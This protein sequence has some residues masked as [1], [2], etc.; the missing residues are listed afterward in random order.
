ML[1]ANSDKKK[2]LLLCRANWL[3]SSI[4]LKEAAENS[5]YQLEILDPNRFILCLRQTPTLLYQAPNEP[6]AKPFPLDFAGVIPRFGTSST[7]Q[8]CRLLRYFEDYGIPVLNNADSIELARNKWKSLY[9]LDRCGIPV[10]STLLNGSETTAKTA[11]HYNGSPTILKTL[12]GSQ[13]VGVILAEQAESAISMLETLQQAN[14]PVLLQQFISE[15]RATDLRCFVIGNRVVTAMQRYGKNGEFRANFHRGGTATSIQ[16]TPEETQLA[17]DATKA[18]G[19]DV[20]GVDLIRS[21]QGALV[22]E[23]NASPGLELIEQTS[24]LDLALQMLLYLERKM[25]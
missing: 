22:L 13:G 19:L 20:A 7:E 12:N 2:L 9:Q 17:I 18:I 6:Q 16:L 14:V 10:P 8:G 25:R 3:Y 21:K 5:G 15:A 11:I 24:K 23:V 1:K 4:R